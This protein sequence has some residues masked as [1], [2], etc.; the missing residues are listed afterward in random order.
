MEVFQEL[1]VQGSSALEGNGSV[2]EMVQGRSVLE[3]R[4]SKI[5]CSGWKWRWFGRMVV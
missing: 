4:W 3:K 1:V 2:L 5:E